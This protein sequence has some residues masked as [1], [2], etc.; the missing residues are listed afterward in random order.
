MASD[1]VCW[2]SATEL[3]AAIRRKKLSPVE[4]IGAVLSRI[5]RL[6]PTLNAFCTVTADTATHK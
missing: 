1:E 6:N 3:A 4:V 5:E 2:L